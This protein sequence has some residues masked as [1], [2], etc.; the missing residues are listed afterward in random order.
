MRLSH[1]PRPIRTQAHHRFPQYLQ[2]RLW[3]EVRLQETV[4]WCGTDHDSTHAWI[5]FLL[6]EHYKPSLDPGTYVKREAEFVIDWYN[7]ELAKLTYG[8]GG[9]GTGPFGGRPERDPAAQ[10]DGI[11]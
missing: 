6:G 5:S 9:F 11:E 3:G 1:N 10:W 7:T 2:R 8:S 4:D